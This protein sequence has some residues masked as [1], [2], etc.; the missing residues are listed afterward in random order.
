M[1]GSGWPQRECPNVMHPSKPPLKKSYEKNPP[2]MAY[3]AKPKKNAFNQA[4][5]LLG[6]SRGSLKS[7]G[8]M[9]KCTERNKLLILA[10][11]REVFRNSRC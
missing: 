6:S 10:T 8:N 1:L 2:V 7:S 3:F 11:A 9:A 4:D 5:I